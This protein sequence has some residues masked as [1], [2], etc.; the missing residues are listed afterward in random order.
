VVGR[1]VGG[2]LG[3]F[4]ADTIGWRWSF[5]VQCPVISVAVILCWVVLPNPNPRDDNKPESSTSNKLRRIDFL[6]GALVI[7]SI[8]SF[9]IPLEIGGQKIAWTHPLIVGMVVA[10]ILLTCAFVIVETQWAQDPILTMSIFTRPGVT[11]TF[12]F[13][14]FQL[15]AQTGVGSTRRL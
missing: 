1:S 4:L 7:L 6:G 11:I 14:V 9:M 3:G 15:A 2:P 8:L 10:G 13:T 12:A 5:L